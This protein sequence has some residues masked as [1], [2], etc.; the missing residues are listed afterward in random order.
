M[1]TNFFLA[2]ISAIFIGRV[3]GYLGSSTFSRK[4]TINLDV[5]DQ[6]GNLTKEIR[7]DKI[8]HAIENQNFVSHLLYYFFG[9]IFNSEF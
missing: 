8:G 9:I 6:Y 7:S 4:M 3:A 1:V 2:L 5:M